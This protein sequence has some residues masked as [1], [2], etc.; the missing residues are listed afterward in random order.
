MI[1]TTCDQKMRLKMIVIRDLDGV[2]QELV[3][4]RGDSSGFAFSFSPALS[5][6][7]VLRLSFASPLRVDCVGPGGRREDALGLKTSHPC[8]LW[9]IPTR[10]NT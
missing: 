2:C 1:N 9:A 10:A 7:V 3:E 5:F 6:V 8:G 4:E